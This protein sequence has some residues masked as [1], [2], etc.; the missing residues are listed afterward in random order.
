MLTA[1]T[2]SVDD[3]CGPPSHV[4]HKAQGG[5]CHGSTMVMRH[6][7]SD[8]DSNGDNDGAMMM[9]TTWCKWPVPWWHDG[10]QQ[11][12]GGGGDMSGQCHCSTIPMMT[13][14]WCRWQWHRWMGQPV[15]D[16][17]RRGRTCM[18]TGATRM[19]VMMMTRWH[20]TSISNN[21]DSMSSYNHLKWKCGPQ[22]YFFYITFLT[23]VNYFD[24]FNF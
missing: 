10:W 12:W 19:P 24:Y 16:N 1:T 7:G 9:M 3:N 14:S 23:V 18:P 21:C 22:V 17:V 5:Q 4:D 20:C 2:T 13:A 6:E 8:N 11:G 15:N